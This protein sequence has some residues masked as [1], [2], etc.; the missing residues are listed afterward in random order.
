MPSNGLFFA[1]ISFKCDSQLSSVLQCRFWDVSLGDCELVD[2]VDILHMW[3][4]KYSQTIL[5]YCL[6]WESPIWI[7]AS[8]ICA[9]HILLEYFKVCAWLIWKC[10]KM[11]HFYLSPGCCWYCCITLWVLWI[12]KN[13]AIDSYSFSKTV[14]IFEISHITKWSL[15][16]KRIIASEQK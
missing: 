4:W 13:L 15:R 2:R 9:T 14:P 10:V 11:L 6:G 12:Q 8:Y 7:T 1:F 5:A 16:E 3:F